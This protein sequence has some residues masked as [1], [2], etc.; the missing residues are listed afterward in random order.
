MNEDNKGLKGLLNKVYGSLD[1][2]WR[3][4]ILFAVGTAV[5]TF[6][7]L[8]VPIFKNTSFERMGVTFE[9]WIFFAVII[10]ANCKTPVESALKTFVFF[11]ISQPLI[12]L[13]QVP[14]SSM[15]WGLFGYYRYWAM[16]TVATLPMAYVG[17]YIKKKNWLSLVILLPV[18]GLLTLDYTSSFIFTFKHFPYQ[19][20]TALFCLAQVLIYLYQFTPTWLHRA[21]GF[22][23]PLAAVLVYTML[24][25]RIDV[26]GTVF[27]PDHIAL[28]ENAEIA[29]EGSDAIQVSIYSYG[30]DSMLRVI[31][32]DYGIV[33]VRITDGDQTYQYHIEVYEDDNGHVQT[34][35][36]REN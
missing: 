3:N 32:K 27:L 15:G 11:L 2:S 36:V 26:N 17:W 16:W 25:S 28:S 4:V 19:I 33:I 7:F 20:V 5:L 21:I 6:I 30:E 29:T 24:T 10:M 12:Y 8:V 34:K 35:A 13:F 23:L 1:M 9:A 18:L 31:A 22:G 14:F